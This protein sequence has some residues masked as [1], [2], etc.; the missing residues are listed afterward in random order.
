MPVE[1]VPDARRPG[2]WTLYAGGVEQSYVVAGDP[3][4]LAFAYVR[5]IAAV[6]DAAGPAGAPLRVLHLGGG[7]LTLP[8]Y[9]AATRPG[10]A[11][12]VVELDPRVVDLVARHLP[13]PASVEVVTGDARA[14]LAGE[15]GHDV[16]V[17]DVFAAARAP[18][19][20][21]TG[22]FYADAARALR[23]A[24][25]LVANVTDVPP[26]AYARTQVAAARSAFPH[27][28][29]LGPAAVLR[30]R[31]AGNVVL[32]ASA[33][34]LPGRVGRAAERVLAGEALVT[35]AAGARPPADGR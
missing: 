16:V 33:A 22:G 25:L 34:P 2:G 35:F 29:A 15:R 17:A 4:H 30:G 3:R 7:A 12:R 21:A 6:L 20:V 5:V 28:A 26:L 8:R 32:A 31:R 13:W 27:V 1:L 9:V 10:S 14:A 19:S 23:P 11:Q 18:D 24:G